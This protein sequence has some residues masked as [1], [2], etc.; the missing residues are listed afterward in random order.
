MAQKYT[1]ARQEANRRYDDKTY[2]LVAVRLR[3]DD[4][5]D[6]IETWENAKSRGMTSRE[7][8]RWLYEKR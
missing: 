6:I 2:Q 3:V 4:D 7:W 1:K 8:I 5:K